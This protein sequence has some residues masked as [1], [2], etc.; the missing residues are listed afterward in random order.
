MLP[1]YVSDMQMFLKVSTHIQ[2]GTAGT[3]YMKKC[4]GSYAETRKKDQKCE[5]SGGEVL[6]CPHLTQQPQILG[7]YQKQGSSKL[8]HDQMV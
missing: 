6:T 2:M 3:H 5:N 1:T 7:W 8:K 4:F